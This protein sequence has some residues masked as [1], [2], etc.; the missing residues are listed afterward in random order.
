MAVMHAERRVSPRRQVLLVAAACC[1]FALG[2]CSAVAAWMV[3]SAMRLP[4]K[5]VNQAVLLSSD[6]VRSGARWTNVSI[7]ARDGS[8]LSAWY[9]QPASAVPG[10]GAVLL[11]HGQGDNREGMLG[12]A[13]W[14]LTHGYSALLPDA[15]G[16]GES[17]G[18]LATY[19]ILEAD[20]VDRWAAWLKTRTDGC[21][22]GL[23]ESMGAA[24]LLSSL[25][26][27][28]SFCAVAAESP[29]ADLREVLGDRIVERAD[30]KLCCGRIAGAVLSRF[31]M[32][33]MRIR[34]G[35]DTPAA[36]PIRA[37]ARTRTPILLIHGGADEIIPVRHSRELQRANPGDVSLWIVPGSEHC[38][39]FATDPAGF[40]SRVL[41]FFA[42]HRHVAG[43]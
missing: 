41:G 3:E 43:P 40:Q 22:Y 9:L 36:A 5:P 30:A 34:Y 19:G 42:E 37:V 29:F 6:A 4:R 8:V 25:A 39:G 31:A 28:P 18:T 23:G 7:Q 32:A 27:S 2:F 24:Q 17:G 38:D 14:L 1:L 26:G 13:S 33:Y 10:S 35:F 12:Y 16:A 15:R 11:L 20:D 21:I